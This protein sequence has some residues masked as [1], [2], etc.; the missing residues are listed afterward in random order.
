MESTT[1]E[2]IPEAARELIAHARAAERETR[3][4]RARSLYEAALRTL[5]HSENASLVAAILRWIARTYYD[6]RHLMASMDCFEA[7]LGVAEAHGNVLGQAHAVNGKGIV[8]QMRGNLEAAAD[9]YTWSLER[10]LAV[11][12]ESLAAMI[13]QNLGVIS[14]IQGDF[15]EALRITLR[16]TGWNLSAAARILAISRPTIHRKIR[17]YGLE[18]GV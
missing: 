5:D 4:S 8:E 12:D 3:R 15:A 17:D 14:N 6:G 10:A 9:H 11:G 2:G 7:A 16:L 13:H 18:E 1:D